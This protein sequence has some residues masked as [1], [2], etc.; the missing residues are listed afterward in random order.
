MVS[1]NN[2][3]PSE[4]FL[5]SVAFFGKQLVKV[6]LERGE[7]KAGDKI[8][9]SSVSGVGAKATT[10]GQT[11]GIALENFSGVVS[12]STDGAITYDRN[13]IGKISLFI[14]L[15]YAKID[16]QIAG[17]TVELDGVGES[18]FWGIDESSGR[19]K[20]IG[21]LDINDFDIIGVKAIYG[22]AGMWSIDGN[23]KLMAKEIE[24]E[25]LIAKASVQ[26]GTKENP[27]G[28]TIFERGTGNPIC[29]YAE[30][31]ILKTTA[32]ECGAEAPL[33]NSSGNTANALELPDS[34]GASLGGP[35]A[36]VAPP[37]IQTS[38]TESTEQVEGVGLPALPT[39]QAGGEAG[40]PTSPEAS[41]E[42]ES[43]PS[44]EII[45]ALTPES[46]IPPS[47]PIPEPSPEPISEPTLSP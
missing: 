13:A 14:N 20:F 45:P 21:V 43:A 28:M 38:P 30:G 44:P 19:I 4:I 6:S 2:P 33:E 9:L 7:I 31:G 35:D 22:S 46:T 27:I 8:S 23:G 36:E 24:T 26:I 32:G 17:G 40:T 25:K 11:I 16:S 34:P 41:V 12:T 42:A 3:D 18:S 37:S 5:N 47:E 1:N 10:S 39:G 29:V 15:G